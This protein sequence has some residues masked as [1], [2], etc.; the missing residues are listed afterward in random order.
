MR[1]I[2]AR[3]ALSFKQGDPVYFIDGAGI[4]T[5]GIYERVHLVQENG[6]VEDVF[7]HLVWIKLAGLSSPVL[8]FVRHKA[9][10]RGQCNDV[11]AVA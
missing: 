1:A 3:A 9:L 11:V 4:V 2:E 6:V 10:K 8:C 5:H 7:G